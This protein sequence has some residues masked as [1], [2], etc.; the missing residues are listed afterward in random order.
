MNLGENEFSM[1]TI[2][3]SRRTF[4]ENFRTQNSFGLFQICCS[5]NLPGKQVHRILFPMHITWVP[6][7][8]RVRFST[9]HHS[10][11]HLFT[12]EVQYFSI[13]FTSMLGLQSQFLKMPGSWQVCRK[14]QKS[15]EVYAEVTHFPLIP[16]SRWSHSCSSGSDYQVA[17]L[18]IFLRLFSWDSIV[19]THK[20]FPLRV[21]ALA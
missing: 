16:Y 13:N 2:V 6:L 17:V 4:A 3:F 18:S 10:P 7:C 5:S 12:H 14:L 11:Q 21:S 15:P 19:H 1:E 9:S 20:K 8:A